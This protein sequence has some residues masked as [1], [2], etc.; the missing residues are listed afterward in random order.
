MYGF[1]SVK[2]DLGRPDS[3]EGG[4]MWQVLMAHQQEAVA[5]QHAAAHSHVN[6]SA[7]TWAFMILDAHSVG[8]SAPLPLSE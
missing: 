1:G 6:S 4:D 2:N 3:A 7:N 8:C 5:S